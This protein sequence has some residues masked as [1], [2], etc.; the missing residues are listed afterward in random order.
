MFEI[1]A[2]RRTKS[3]PICFLGNDSRF[4]AQE[5][6]AIYCVSLIVLPDGFRQDLCEIYS[7]AI[8]RAHT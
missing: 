7:V 4:Q 8:V 6:P 2:R 3:L 1:N 5:S